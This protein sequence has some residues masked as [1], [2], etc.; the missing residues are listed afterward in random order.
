MGTIYDPIGVAMNKCP[1]SVGDCVRFVP[2]SRTKGLYQ[3]LDRF[4]LKI[5]EIARIKEIRD[6]IFLYFEEGRG[7][8][9]WNEFIS[10]KSDEGSDEKNGSKE[11]GKGSEKGV[12]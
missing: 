6:G 12:L 3:N 10:D 7:G 11:G 8:F 1:F 5:G 9:P 2:S 4:G